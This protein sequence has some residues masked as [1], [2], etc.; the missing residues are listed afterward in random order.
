M[1]AQVRTLAG[2]VETPFQSDTGTTISTVS[3]MLPS[4]LLD[5][6]SAFDL[7]HQSAIKK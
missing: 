3:S 7:V 1:L 6:V 5:S 4:K 2:Y